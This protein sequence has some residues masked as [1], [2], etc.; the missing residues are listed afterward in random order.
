MRLRLQKG[1][2]FGTLR[3]R[4]NDGHNY[5]TQKTESTVI[6]TNQ[7]F[8]LLYLGLH[9]HMCRQRKDIYNKKLKK[10]NIETE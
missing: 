8:Q 10:C 9:E 6:L 7:K 1:K 4:Q 3:L 5:I 2:L